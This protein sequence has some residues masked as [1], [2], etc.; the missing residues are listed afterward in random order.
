MEARSAIFILRDM[1]K[2]YKNRRPSTNIL[3][4][5]NGTVKSI[6][7]TPDVIFDWGLRGCSYI[8]ED[9]DIQAAI[10]R[11]PFFSDKAPQLDR[12]WTDD[13]EPEVKP[14][15]VEKPRR[16]VRRASATEE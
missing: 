16:T 10:E 11:H 7:F 3:V 2:L 8:T 4:A 6:E 5:V 15:V 9:K 13:K 1:K 14:E 12:I